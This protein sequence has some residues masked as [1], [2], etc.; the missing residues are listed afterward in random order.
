[1]YATFAA[2]CQSINQSINTNRHS[3]T[4][5]IQFSKPKG[6][7]TKGEAVCSFSI[8]LYQVWFYDVALDFETVRSDGVVFCFSFY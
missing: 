4:N 2:G 6:G 1:M 7:E 5:E 8:N 3:N